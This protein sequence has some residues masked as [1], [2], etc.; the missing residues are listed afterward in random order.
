VGLV[1]LFMVIL[2]INYYLHGLFYPLFKVCEKSVIGKRHVAA[3]QKSASSVIGKE[4]EDSILGKFY[5][6]KRSRR[7]HP[8]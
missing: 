8:W 2:G 4:V 6:R 1:M 3:H 5:P 7:F